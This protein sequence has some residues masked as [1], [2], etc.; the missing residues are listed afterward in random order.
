MLHYVILGLGLLGLGWGY[1]TLHYIFDAV[2]VLTLCGLLLSLVSLNG[3]PEHPS[4]LADLWDLWQM[5]FPP[6]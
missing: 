1:V 2:W 6:G 3:K 5:F 4:L